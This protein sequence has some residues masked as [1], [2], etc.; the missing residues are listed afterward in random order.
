MED[1]DIVL[2][3][4]EKNLKTFF[5]SKKLR[6]EA[7]DRQVEKNFN[8]DIKPILALYGDKATVS[9]FNIKIRYHDH[10][11]INYNYTESNI[12]INEKL[13]CFVEEQD[14]LEFLTAINN[15]EYYIVEYENKHLTSTPYFKFLSKKKAN[16]DKVK[17]TDNISRIFD[18]NGLI[19][20]KKQAK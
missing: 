9:N 2:N 17:K 8:E 19:Y 15:D 11:I 6:K 5:K 18:I 1:L 7:V 20:S 10:F 16:I 14:L 3:N 12:Y 13:Y 4:C